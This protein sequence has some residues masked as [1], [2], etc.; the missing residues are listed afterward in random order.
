M[1]LSNREKWLLTI[2]NSTSYIQGD[3]RLQKY[4]LFVDKKIIEEE[5]YD[6]WKAWKFGAY[7][8]KLA[9]DA[10]S[11]HKTG[12]IIANQ[13]TVQNNRPVFRYTLSDIGREEIYL[14]ETENTESVQRIKELL[15]NYFHKR[16]DELLADSYEMFKEFTNESTIRAEVQRTQV[17]TDSLLS[18][19]YE[20]S[21]DSEDKIIPYISSSQELPINEHLFNDDDLRERL[22]KL[23]GL[24]KTPNLDQNSF[25]RLSGKLNDKIKSKIDSVELVRSVRG[26]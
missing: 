2:V 15:E 19:N 3:T 16:L 20:L 1:E 24:E 10:K 18:T 13:V 14:F 25:D 22:A 6:D 8:K 26:S 9:Q 4:V 17:E 5:L 12:L 7:S 23:A 21:F 11:L